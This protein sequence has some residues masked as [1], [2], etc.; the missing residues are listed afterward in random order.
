MEEAL[1]AY[2]EGLRVM[3]NKSALWGKKT[4]VL[5]SLGRD[6]ESQEARKKTRTALVAGTVS[7]PEL[8]DTPQEPF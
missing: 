8:R 1:A 5:Q 4:V 7:P 2:E 3:P 6:R